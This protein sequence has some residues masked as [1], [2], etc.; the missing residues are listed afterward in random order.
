M[1]KNTNS[2]KIV[3][4]TSMSIFSLFCVFISTFA[5]FY[6]NRAVDTNGSG[7][8]ITDGI[9]KIKQIDVFQEVRNDNSTIS[10]TDYLYS[11]TAYYSYTPDKGWF[12][13]NSSDGSMIQLG[14]FSQE[15]NT[16]SVLIYISLSEPI[17]SYTLSFTTTTS[18]DNSRVKQGNFLNGDSN[19]LSSFID[20][21]YID[22]NSQLTTNS[23]SQYDISSSINTNSSL[24]FVDSTSPSSKELY[25]TSTEINSKTSTT[26]YIALVVEY[27]VSVVNYIFY[28]LNFSNDLL[29]NSE[30]TIPF[31]CDWSID[32]Q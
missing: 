22:L 15:D 8:T 1:K 5:W 30:S 17:N 10:P 28:T 13:S 9:K 12:S 23:S 3:A 24:S 29:G 18:Y 25:K 2:F 14:T 11:S 6:A 27:N 31:N 16:H 21:K 7:F 4:A 32:L 26:N 19:P 20:F